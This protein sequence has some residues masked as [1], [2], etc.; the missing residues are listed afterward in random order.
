SPMLADRGYRSKGDR[1]QLDCLKDYVD[2]QTRPIVVE[3]HNR[4]VEIRNGRDHAEAESA[5]RRRSASL[6]A[7][8]ALKHL[9]MLLFRNAWSVV[10]N[11]ASTLRAGPLEGNG[12]RRRRW[13]MC[14]CILNEIGKELGDEVSIAA[15]LAILLDLNFKHV[16]TVICHAGIDSGQ[17]LD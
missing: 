6:Q 5:S 8:Q 15:N 10:C 2:D 9:L 13:D 16:S 1:R 17:I 11:D 3:P 4:A 14:Q 12:Y 7:I